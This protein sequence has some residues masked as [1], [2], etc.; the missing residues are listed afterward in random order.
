MPDAPPRD[1]VL[2]VDDDL[3]IAR[4]VELNLSLEGFE[5][6]VANEGHSAVEKALTLRP[7]AILLDVMMPGLDGYEVCR[8][9]RSNA[10]T[11]HAA[12]IMLTAKALSADT[13]LGLTSGAD[14]YIAKPFEP[15]EL[16]A[17][18]R[19]ALRRAKQLRDLSPLTGLPGNSEIVR[20]VEQLIAEH[21]P[22]ALAYADLDEFK[23]YNDRYGFVR[24]DTAIRATA[25]VLMDAVTR[26][27]GDICFLGHIGGDDFA[28]IVEPGVAEELC[29]LAIKGFDAMAPSLYDPP[30]AATGYIEVEDRHNVVH[31]IGIMTISI[32]VA[33][34][35]HRDIRTPSEASAIATEMKMAAKHER[36]SAYR[37]DQRQT[38]GLG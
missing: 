37:I 34:T 6:H 1:R 28:L 18:V 36:R 15:P 17:R 4:Y 33:T 26:I 32:G 31:R 35:A 10:R 22:F 27:A 7:D 20:Q 30:D 11:S 38:P 24:G 25:E 16:V 2:V 8:R 12:I 23:G 5:V 9:L 3:D 29:A 21:E 13:V 14:D 19:A